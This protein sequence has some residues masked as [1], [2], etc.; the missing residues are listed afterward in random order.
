VAPIY[1]GPANAEQVTGAPWRWCRDFAKANGIAV[2]RAGAKSF[3]RADELAAA[4]AR[5][6]V[7]APQQPTERTYESMLAELRLTERAS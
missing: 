2:L 3:I 7:A 4:I 6:A 1:I 5:A